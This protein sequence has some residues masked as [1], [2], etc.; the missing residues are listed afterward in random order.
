MV[1]SNNKNKLFRVY[2]E[3]QSSGPSDCRFCV[4]LAPNNMFSSMSVQIYIHVDTH[5]SED[6]NSSSDHSHERA[7]YTV[8]IVVHKTRADRD[9]RRV[10]RSVIKAIA[11]E[12][13]RM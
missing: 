8:R 13:R 7:M 2:G 6:I 1:N 5:L 10:R 11:H 9:D 4:A 3:Q 12:T